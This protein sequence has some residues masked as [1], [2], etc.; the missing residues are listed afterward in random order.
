L[1]RDVRYADVPAENWERELKVL[2]LPGHLIAH[3]VT[4]GELHRAGRYD[5]LSDGVHR[6]TGRTAMGVREWVSLQSDAF[7]G[8]AHLEHH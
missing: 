4:M 8:R 3:V 1:D 6:V 7:V 2:G 5:R